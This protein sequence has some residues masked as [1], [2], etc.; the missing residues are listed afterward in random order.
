VDGVA[1]TT[2]EVRRA[3]EMSTTMA[4]TVM[5]PTVMT[6]AVMA[7]AMM[8]TAVAT[9]AMTTTFRGGIPGGRQHGR[10]NNEANLDIEF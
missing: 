5:A 7:T 8:T 10:E 4:A 2:A 1:P 9:T 6:T 3:A